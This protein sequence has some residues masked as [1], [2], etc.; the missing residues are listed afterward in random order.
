M[1][2]I[3]AFD[4]YLVDPAHA[5]Q[6]VSPGYDAVSPE[7]RRE[8]AEANPQNYLN[9]MR[10]REDFPVDAQPT[11]EHL[12]ALNKSKLDELLSN[13]SFNRFEK[14]CLFIY[15]LSVNDHTQ[16]GVVC[17]IS[18]DEYREGRLRKHENTRSDK[19]DLLAMYQKVV[20]VSSSPICLAYAHDDDIERLL[21]QC[22]Q[23]PPVL[24]FVS[25]D[26]IAQQ[27]W[28][29]ESGP[30]QRQ[31]EALF[32]RIETTYLTDGHHRAASGLRYARMMRQNE[33]DSATNH[34]GNHAD[35]PY[36]QLLVALFST[37]Q[38]ALLPFHRAVRDLNGL[39]EAELV[40]A[41]ERDFSVRA[42]SGESE[43]SGES[44][45]SFEPARHGEFGMLVNDHWYQLR[46]R[47]ELVDTTDPVN[48]LD[49]SILQ[50]HILGPILGITD[51]RGDPRLDY[52]SGVIGSD[53]L[54]QK[55]AAGWA[56]CF[57][58]FATSIDQLMTVADAGALMPPKSTYFDP[59]AHSGIFIRPK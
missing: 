52:V 4:G 26:G 54:K 7:Q 16:T 5:E 14:P 31:L 3:R 57:A 59:K 40:N 29:I 6:V 38:L 24:D 46:I 42:V 28:R 43:E 19:E 21:D 41:L 36:N 18:I 33:S 30:L 49:V 13:G 2:I 45:A 17:E 20:G 12:L 27:V 58:C 9:T 35:A 48:S 50:N 39:S 53:G 10:L 15:R 44:E 56:V 55:C 22:T 47:K 32:A 37:E 23:Q 51:V 34:A 25:P 11:V 8:F 1:P